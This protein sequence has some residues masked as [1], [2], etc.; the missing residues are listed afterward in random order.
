MQ[1]QLGERAEG[2]QITI[3]VKLFFKIV[4]VFSKVDLCCYNVKLNFEKA[5]LCKKYL[6]FWAKYNLTSN[7]NYQFML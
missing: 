6:N 2:L 5:N 3:A 1:M 4:N 7:Y